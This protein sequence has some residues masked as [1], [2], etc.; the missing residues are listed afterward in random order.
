[1]PAGKKAVSVIGSGWDP[2]F[3]SIQRALAAA[4][5]LGGESITTFGPGRSM[6]HTTTVKSL[7]PDI[8]EAVAL[9]LPGAKPG[10]QKREVYIQLNEKL[11]SSEVRDAIVAK[12]LS[13]QGFRDDDSH[14]F[15]VKSIAPHDTQN[16][17]GTITCKADDAEVSV[18]LHG[19][20][21]VMTANVMIAAARAAKRLMD[22]PRYGCFTTV[23]IEPLDFIRGNT[24]AER[25]ARIKY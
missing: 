6:G 15:F 20:N 17:G 19:S 10:M 7:H 24:V 5:V 25:L 13:H 21:P 22:R 8:R 12:V 9:T 18:K 11:Q 23:E 3:D 14:V 16:H 1:M 4:A 2:G